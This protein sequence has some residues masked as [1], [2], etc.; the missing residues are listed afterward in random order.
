MK[1]VTPA[2]EIGRLGA[3]TNLR[4]GGVMA[5]AQHKRDARRTRR[6]IKAALRRG[7]EG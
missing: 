7:D 3:P 2:V 1:H 5:S 4:R 6:A